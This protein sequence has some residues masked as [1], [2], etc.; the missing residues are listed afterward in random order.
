M[1]ESWDDY[2]QDWDANSD[3]TLY[4]ERAYQSLVSVVDLDGLTVLDFGAGTGLLSEKIAK[5]AKA[6]VALDSSVKMIE[7]LQKK[8]LPRVT[9]LACEISQETIGANA[10]LQ[11]RLQSG[12]DLIVASSVCAFVP[13]YERTLIDLGSLLKPGGLFVQ[14]DW[15]RTDEEA[16]SGFSADDLRQAYTRAGLKVVDIKTAFSLTSDQ[17]SMPVLMGIAQKT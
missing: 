7:A 8:H 11:C 9:A 14:W 6:V 15:L 1:S 3:V 10:V 4:A 2:A 5:L 16:D 12:F 17:G 13:D